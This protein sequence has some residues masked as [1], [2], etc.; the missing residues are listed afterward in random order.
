MSSPHKGSAA[1]A[2]EHG[3]LSE[4]WPTCPPPGADPPGDHLER[5]LGN[6]HLQMIAIGGAIGTG[7]FM[8][9]GKTISLAGP[10]ILFVYAIIGFFLFFVMRAMGELLLSNLKYK[11]FRDIAEDILG[12]WAGFFAGWTY[13]FCWI[14]IGMADLV[15]VTAYVSYWAPDLPKWIPSV[16]LV[17]LLLGLNLVT[18]KLFGEIEFW[19]ALIKVITIVALIVVA[20]IMV[21][22]GFVAPDGHR[23]ALDNLWNDGGMFPMGAA[24]FLAGFQIAFF[25]FLGIELVGTAAAETKDPSVTLPKAINAIPIRVGLFYILALAAIMSVTPWR[26]I[27]PSVSPFVSMFG[28]AGIGIAASVVNFVV[29]TSA[30]SSANSGIYST[31]RMLYGLALDRKAPRLFGVLSKHK[32]PAKGLIF[33]CCCLAPGIVLLYSTDSIVEAFT[34][35]TTVASVLFIFVWSLIL[36]SY[37]V[38][39]K[40]S[41]ELHEASTY[42]VPGGPVMCWTVLAFFVGIVVILAMEP[43]TRMALAVTP[44]W[45]LILGLVYQRF[46]FRARREESLHT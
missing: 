34:L 28:L 39:R 4:N 46:R 23:A 16:C 21:A 14:V 36:C 27:D 31:S 18:V 11:S 13:W 15:A 17:L 3:D 26:L 2:G 43:D 42:K 41:P 29:L 40:R 7:L 32:V 45:F 8:G 35:A 24:G 44:V 30:A 19:F 1:P 20:I 38:F 5:A 12:P 37:L 33:S 22:S 25:A 10:S 6:R 9:S